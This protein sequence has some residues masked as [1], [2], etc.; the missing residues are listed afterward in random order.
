[1][2]VIYALSLRQP[3]FTDRYV[4]WIAPALMMLMALGAV[5]VR[6]HALWLGR[7]LAAGLAIYVLAMWLYGGW[8]QKTLPMKYDL[9]AGV[10]YVEA[11]RTPDELLIL[12][13]PYLEWA[14]RYYTSDQGT[15]PFANSDARLGRWMEGLWTNHGWSDDEAWADVHARMV[16]ATAD[17]ETVWL[18]RSEPEMWD[19]RRLMEQW[20]EE[21]GDVI[22][23]A[24]FVGVQAR[25][26]RLE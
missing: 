10:G 8:Q 26:Y 3:V 13:I 25:R 18:L 7:T 5:V 19:S 16:E 1:V 15:R 20:L 11:R 6:T 14:Y 17:A 12:Q 9:R 2:L 23:R 4:L 22:A 24:A 21:H